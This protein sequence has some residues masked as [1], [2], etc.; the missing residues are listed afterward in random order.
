MDSKEKINTVLFCMGFFILGIL[1]VFGMA[2][3]Y[4]YFKMWICIK[5]E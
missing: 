5:G 2:M 3:C 4:F 1:S